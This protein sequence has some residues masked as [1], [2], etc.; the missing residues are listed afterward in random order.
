[1]ANLAPTKI[2][3]P[4]NYPTYNRVDLN[5]YRHGATY[6][7]TTYIHIKTNIA[8]YSGVMYMIELN[9]YNYGHA[10]AIQCAFTGY[11]YDD[12]S[13]PGITIYNPTQFQA[14]PGLTADGQY[15]S[16][17][18]FLVL[19]CFKSDVTYANFSMDCYQTNPITSTVSP[20]VTAIAVNNTSGAHY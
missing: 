2:I 9:G 16:S 15:L 14:Y 3:L 13:R 10:Q 18:N 7:A 5:F 19:R 4:L 8:R 11:M 12:G 6:S 17:D 1:M 20:Q